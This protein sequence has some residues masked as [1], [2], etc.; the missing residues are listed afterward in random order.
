[1]RA[2][3]NIV[4]QDNLKKYLW[5]F[6][7]DACYRNAQRLPVLQSKG[8]SSKVTGIIYSGNNNTLWAETYSTQGLA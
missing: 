8:Q 6:I 3:Q 1:V 2:S 7:N 5:V 4:K